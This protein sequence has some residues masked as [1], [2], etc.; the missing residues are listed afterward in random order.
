MSETTVACL[1]DSYTEAKESFDWIRALKQRPGNASFRF[2]NFGIGGDLAYNAL[3]R[4]P[5]VVNCH[6]D[7]LIV[8][9]G[10]N[11]VMA[12]IV[13]QLSGFYRRTK[14]LP[15]EPSPDWY[16]ENMQSIVRRLKMETQARIALCS[17]PPL[18]EDPTSV[19]PLQA[20]ANRRVAEYN[21]TI[22]QITMDEGVSYLPVHERLQEQILASPGQ[23]FA[24]PS[25]LQ[26]G[27]DAFNRL[28]L[29]RSLDEV[30]RRN[31]WYLHTDGI[32]LNS[33]GGSVLVDLV[34][35]FISA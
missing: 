22:K 34:Q 11:D 7:R 12:L 24:T 18:G 15:V 19:V 31:G 29:R 20:E 33:R 5:D 3:Q 9:L 2:Y 16:R 30:G 6:P 25:L 1:G 35:E 32:H 27:R 13:K 4:L 28:V 21:A 8:L 17:L 23:A 10:T 14:H 26:L